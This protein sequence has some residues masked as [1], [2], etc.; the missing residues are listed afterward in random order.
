MK[1]K[2]VLVVLICII[3]C[4]LSFVEIFGRKVDYSENENRHLASWPELSID[5]FFDGTYVEGMESYLCDHF[6]M[7]DKLMGMYA[8][9]LRAQGAT[10]VNNVYIC[11]EGYLIEKNESY[12]NLDKIVRK[13]NGFNNKI[14]ANGQEVNISVML[15]PTSITINSEILPSYAD[16]GNELEAIN[17]IYEGLRENIS[18]IRVDETL[19]K[20]NSNFQTF[21]KTDHHWTTYG[22]Y[23]AYKEYAKSM[24]FSYHMITDYDIFEVSSN[25]KGTVYSK[26]NDLT[27]ESESITAFYQKQNLTIQ[28][29]NS[30][31]DSLYNKSYLEQKDKYSFF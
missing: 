9:S 15:V 16:K 4:G 7:R 26:V 21:Y 8:L 25:F 17:Y 3:M 13:I 24:N 11:D 28:Y 19:K 6:P 29:Q 30:T 2:K 20:E 31:S 5:T 1:E 22:A 23:F 10:E 12:E 18:K 14:N 27:T